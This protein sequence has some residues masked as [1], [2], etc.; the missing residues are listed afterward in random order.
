MEWFKEGDCFQVVVVSKY[1]GERYP[2]NEYSLDEVHG[3]ESIKRKKLA[4]EGYDV[5]GYDEM[6]SQL[7]NEYLEK[8][9]KTKNT[10]EC[11]DLYDEYEQKKKDLA[12][13]FFWH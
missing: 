11:A 2:S 9:S 1:D 6:H 7:T 5:G 3:A 4:G 8:F 10:F 13:E 12:M